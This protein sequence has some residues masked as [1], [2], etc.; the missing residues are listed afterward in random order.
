MVRAHLSLRLERVGVGV[1]Q[2]SI[3]GPIL[4]SLHINDLHLICPEVQIQ[5]YAEDTVLYSHAKTKELHPIS[6]HI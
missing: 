1:P 5:M 6:P 3:L 2:G 4:F